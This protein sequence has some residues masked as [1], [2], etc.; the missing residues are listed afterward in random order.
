MSYQSANQLQNDGAFNGRNQS[1][2]LQQAEVFKDDARP[3]WVSL[4]N[5]IMRDEGGLT[6]TFVRLAANGPGIADKVDNGDGTIDQE[7]VTD[8]DLL[9]LTQANWPVVAGLYFDA[10]GKPLP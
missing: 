4:A 9:S 5:G 7:K 1:V 10:D 3:G 8:A 6:Q 2:C